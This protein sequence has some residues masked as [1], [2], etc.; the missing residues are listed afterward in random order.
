MDV[1]QLD[2]ASF[3]KLLDHSPLQPYFREQ[4]IRKAIEECKQ[5][6]FGAIYVGGCWL[7]LAVQELAGYDIEV[8]I[9]VGFPFGSCSTE[10]KL[11]EAQDALEKGATVL[12]LQVN[13]GFLKDKR[14][15][16]VLAEIAGLVHV[17]KGRATTKIIIEVNYLTRDEIVTACKLVE[18]AGADYAKT[19]SGRGD[20]GPYLW[21]V[22]LMRDVLSPAVKVKASG[23]GGYFPTEIALA[24]LRAGAER[25]GTRRGVEIL[26]G[27]ELARSLGMC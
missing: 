13:T 10:A 5:Y 20:R 2:R 6:G 11:A 24:C 9:G 15:K 18:E 14:Y 3:A 25:I 7:P 22:K 27:F 8:G 19:S 17:A 16:E 1:T 26:E 12:D 21:E 23:I 4:D